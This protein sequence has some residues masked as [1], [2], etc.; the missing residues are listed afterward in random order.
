MG[1]KLNRIRLELTDAWIEAV[2]IGASGRRGWSQGV[3]VLSHALGFGDQ[4]KALKV[5]G[6][7]VEG[8]ELKVEC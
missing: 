4:C 8:L 6:L 5:E 2:K 7:G 1:G 3:A